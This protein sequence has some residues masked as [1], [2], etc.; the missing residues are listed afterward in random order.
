MPP[1]R[2]KERRASAECMRENG[3]ED[4]PDPD[5]RG[6]VLYYGDDPDLKSASE[7]CAELTRADQGRR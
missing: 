1:R 4:F 2:L 5:S 6:Y 7:K 3:V